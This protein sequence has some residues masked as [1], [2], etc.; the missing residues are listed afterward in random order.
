MSRLK[1]YKSKGPGQQYQVQAHTYGK[2]WEDEGYP[3]KIVMICFVPRDGELRDSFY[4]WEP[5]DRSIAEKYL[6]RANNRYTLLQ[7]LG[8]QATLDLWP[9]CDSTS[10]P[11]WE[12]CPWCNPLR[13][14]SNYNRNPFAVT[15]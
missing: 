8:L 14:A 15:N 5:Y 9:L 10:N 6:D 4:W 11:D 12:W 1:K 2:G 3:V 7:T 13:T